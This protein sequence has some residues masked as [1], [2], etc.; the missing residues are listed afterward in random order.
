M[1]LIVRQDN[2]FGSFHQIAL[3]P[4]RLQITVEPFTWDR[5]FAFTFEECG[6]FTM[7]LSPE[8]IADIRA[9]LM[10][11]ESQQYN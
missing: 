10:R 11:L 6:T 5:I 7:R 8:A 2:T 4:Q 3:R 9:Q 1:G